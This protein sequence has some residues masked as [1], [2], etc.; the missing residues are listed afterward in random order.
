M[1]EDYF[2]DAAGPLPPQ[3]LTAEQA[4]LGA[5]LIEPQAALIAL[6]MLQAGDFY[7]E[8]HQVLF[9]AMQRAH[10]I[11]GPVDLI[12]VSAQLRAREGLD[13]AGGAEYLTALVNSCPTAAHVSRYAAIV[14]EKARRRE[15]ILLTAELQAGLYEGTV[16]PEDCIARFLPLHERKHQESGDSAAL[17]ADHLAWLETFLQAD[18][19]PELPLVGIPSLDRQ[20]GGL[21]RQQVVLVKGET[22]F[23]KTTLMRQSALETARALRDRGEKGQVLY[24]SLEGTISGWQT[25]AVSY[26]GHV[27]RYYLR[28][29]AL[30]QQ[31]ETG[32]RVWESIIAAEAEWAGLP[33]VLREFSTTRKIAE[34][35]ADALYY[36]A[37]GPRVRAIYIDYLQ[38]V[39]A[40][41]RDTTGKVMQA[42][43]SLV[44]LFART[45]APIIA[46]AQVTRKEN[47][48]KSTAWASAAENDASLVLQLDRGEPNTKNG[49]E[50]RRSRFARI[51]NTK[52]REDMNAREIELILEGE[53]ARF[54]ERK[55]GE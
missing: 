48:E 5:M 11:S 14:S 39:E 6:R 51:K 34:I 38:R 17:A 20:V 44:D 50:A 47:G 43:S 9:R 3:D 46:G 52:S 7:L 32:D 42:S 12:T 40:P 54:V 24:Y 41:G 53:Y 2:T 37:R 10:S 13:A 35:T 21:G 18:P 8:A 22:G 31:T 55:E 23:G 16:K 19:R 28:H 4:T 36:Q 26:L 15:A 45:G 27:N 1:T 25:G 30:H 49:D 29:G 33:L